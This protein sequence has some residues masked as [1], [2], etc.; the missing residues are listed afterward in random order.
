MGW[1]NEHYGGYCDHLQFI[2]SY[3]TLL[4]IHSLLDTDLYDGLSIPWNMPFIRVKHSQLSKLKNLYSPWFVDK[5]SRGYQVR[6]ASS[7]LPHPSTWSG[8]Q[9]AKWWTVRWGRHKWQRHPLPPLPLKL[10]VEGGWGKRWWSAS[11]RLCVC[12]CPCAPF[13]VSFSFRCLN[14]VFGPLISVQQR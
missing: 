3:P 14:T 2:S 1:G 11:G 7:H 6:F 5:D 9:W 8:G 13:F 12:V 4:C 10:Q